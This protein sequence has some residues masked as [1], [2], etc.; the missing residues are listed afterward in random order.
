MWTKDEER[1]ILKYIDSGARESDVLDRYGKHGPPCPLCNAP[2]KYLP[3]M[4]SDA[5]DKRVIV[6]IGKKMYTVN[7]LCVSCSRSEIGL[8]HY[9]VTDKFFKLEKT[10]PAIEAIKLAMEEVGFE[11]EVKN[12]D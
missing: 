10:K 1:V 12:E 8:K 2:V 9:A 5:V 6:K 3:F 7:K 4:Q 11:Y